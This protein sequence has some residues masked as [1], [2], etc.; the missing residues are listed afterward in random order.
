MTW[1]FVRMWPCS[2]MTEPEP[3][4][5]PPGSKKPRG[6][7]VVLME[8]TPGERAR[9]ASMLFCSSVAT[10]GSV[11]PATFAFAALLSS[12]LKAAVGCCRRA[13]Q[14]SKQATPAAANSAD[15]SAMKRIWRAEILYMAL[16][17][18][19]LIAFSKVVFSN[20]DAARLPGRCALGRA[21]R[22][23]LN[24]LRRG[25]QFYYEAAPA[26]V[27]RACERRVRHTREQGARRTRIHK[28]P[29]VLIQTVWRKSS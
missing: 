8:T 27:R 1:K 16:F 26:R 14:R 25:R 23:R 7:V 11:M 21:P 24:E 22:Q 17:P 15:K 4:T 13:P 28:R 3:P 6:R 12:L 5:V 29:S 10:E 9:K 20:S 19:D 2:S 18:D